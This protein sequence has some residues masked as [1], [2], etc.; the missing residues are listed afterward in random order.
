MNKFCIISPFSINFPECFVRI[1]HTTIQHSLVIIKLFEFFV[2]YPHTNYVSRTI[3]FD[4]PL[5]LRSIRLVK[6]WTL[7]FIV[8]CSAPSKT[9]GSTRRDKQRSRV[10]AGACQPLGSRYLRLGDYKI[11]NYHRMRYTVHRCTDVKRV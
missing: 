4:R 3:M 2:N 11:K 9:Y 6:Q 1:M 5:E 8:R 7:S 10:L